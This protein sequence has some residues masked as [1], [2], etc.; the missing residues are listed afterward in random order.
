MKRLGRVL[1]ANRGEIA[2]RVLRACHEA[3]LP[4]AAVFSA[5]DRGSPHVWLADRAVE[6]GPAPAR[7]SYLDVD[8]ILDAAREVEAG[9]VHPGYGFLAENAEFAAAVEAAGLVWIGPPASAI[10]AMGEKTAARRAMDAAGVPVIPGTLNALGDAEAAL[11]AAGRAGYPVLLKAAAGGGGKGMRVVAGADEMAG[12]FRAASSEAASAFGDPALYLERYL[13]EARHV[14]I[15]VLAD[16]R[17]RAIHLGE[18]EC[19]LQRRHQ[20]V[21]EEAPAPDLGPGL[22]ERMGEVAVRAAEAVGYAGAGTVEFL[23]DP[24]GS[25]WFLE[26]NTRLQ[27]EHPVT[28]WVTGVD[29]VRAQ[30]AI[31]AGGPLPLEQEELAL[32]GHAIECR[33]AA[34][35]P[36]RGFLPATGRIAAYS[37]PA[38]PGVRVDSGVR[39]G[40]EVTPHYDP[41]LLKLVV[42]GRERAE[43]LD[44]MSRALAELEIVGVTTNIGF[45]RALVAHPDVRGGALHTRWLE[46][47]ADEIVAAAAAMHRETEPLAAALA[48]WRHV[49]EGAAPAREPSAGRSDAGTGWRSAARWTGLP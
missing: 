14:E 21:L 41:L 31:A 22:R 33:I 15:Q 36:A 11:A 5:A 9:S 10:R 37:E 35:D 42:H 17:G 28:E 39:A 13:P 25:F 16:Q 23:L 30:L 47:R 24:D 43:A 6:I 27:V 34:E 45:Q 40:T 4:T 1:V 2:V 8:R 19:S 48:A 46:A 26:M 12:A 29:V 32:T 18:R 44:R 3:R 7:A 49:E 38:G 20:K